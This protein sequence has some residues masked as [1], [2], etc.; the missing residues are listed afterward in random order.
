MCNHDSNEKIR[1]GL[2]GRI[3]ELSSCIQAER[4]KWVICLYWKMHNTDEAYMT[5]QDLPHENRKNMQS[6]PVS[7]LHHRD[8]DI[9]LESSPGDFGTMEEDP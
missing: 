9:V 3:L 5:R 6:F 7:G 1:K 2:Q 8:L 4:S